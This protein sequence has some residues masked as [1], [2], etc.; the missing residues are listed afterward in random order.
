MVSNPLGTRTL[1][2]WTLTGSIIII[3]QSQPGTT[4]V[5]L[6]H[7]YYRSRFSPVMAYLRYGAMRSCFA[8]LMKSSYS[9]VTHL[10]AHIKYKLEVSICVDSLFRTIFFT[11]FRKTA[12]IC[13]KRQ[14]IRPSINRSA[15]YFRLLL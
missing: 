15:G 5:P 11:L 14:I 4:T 8:R 3:K 9:V 1:C 6:L 12:L 7:G 2:H 13:S 10:V